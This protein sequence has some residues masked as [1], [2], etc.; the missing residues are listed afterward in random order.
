MAVHRL[1]NLLM[2]M[3]IIL[4][5]IPVNVMCFVH[6]SST[7]TDIKSVMPEEQFTSIMFSNDFCKFI[8]NVVDDDDENSVDINGGDDDNDDINDQIDQ[9]RSKR[10]IRSIFEMKEMPSTIVHS[11]RHHHHHNNLHYPHI[12]SISKEEESN[13]SSSSSII[14]SNLKN[15]TSHS[16]MESLPLPNSKETST[17][18][19]SIRTRRQDIGSVQIPVINAAQNQQ[20]PHYLD[21]SSHIQTQPILA[22]PTEPINTD[23]LIQDQTTTTTTTNSRE[24]RQKKQNKKSNNHI[25][26]KKNPYHYSY[27]PP[28]NSHPVYI[29]LE[30][31]DIDH[32]ND[33]ENYFSLQLYLFEMWEEPRL[34]TTALRYWS[35]KS[36]PI[37]VLEANMADCLWTP[38]LIF[39]DSTEKEHLLPPTNILLAHPEYNRSLVLLRK[40]RYSLKVRCHMNLQIYPMDKHS[41]NFKIR[42]FTDPIRKVTLKWLSNSASPKPDLLDVNQNEVIYSTEFA[43]SLFDIRVQRP[44]GYS[45][46]NWLNDYYSVLTVEFIFER[47]I[48]HSLLTV[49]IPSSLIVTLSWLQ[50]WFDVEAVPGRMSLG[51]MSTLTIMTQILTNYEKAGNH[52]TA[53]DIWLFVC[54]IMVFLALMEYA[55]AYTISHYYDNFDDDDDN[56][57]GNDDDGSHVDHNNNNPFGFDH[58][59]QSE[60]LMMANTGIDSMMSSKLDKLN[61]N[62]ITSAASNPMQHQTL[63]QAAISNNNNN[64]VSPLKTSSLPTD[65]FS[66]ESAKETD[67]KTNDENRPPSAISTNDRFVQAQQRIHSASKELEQLLCEKFAETLGMV[68]SAQR[69]MLDAQRL[70]QTLSLI[71]QQ[72]QLTGKQSTIIDSNNNRNNE[73]EN[74]KFLHQRK[75]MRQSSRPLTSTTTTATNKPHRLSK[76]RQSLRRQMSSRNLKAVSSAHRNRMGGYE[77]Q[78]S[79][80]SEVDY[81]S[82]YLFPFSFVLFAIGYWTALIYYKLMS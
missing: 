57:D 63:F 17:S 36:E 75:P 60:S 20:Q 6:Q 40:S 39:E 48:I 4:Y 26:Y 54:L 3:T 45:T 34:N 8:F 71:Q 73:N 32:I 37:P 33:A 67:A 61:N 65:L 62:P 50:F 14:K 15:L 82:R 77:T 12:H 58:L 59:G 41:C 69:S 25:S 35:R 51:I 56:N 81:C 27:S 78:R 70:Q 52:V 74:C 7:Q 76:F 19:S 42:T 16:L 80:L 24:R 30:I 13:T 66:N 55:L 38:S 72:Q 49:Y 43:P 79:K 31:L 18:S 22:D 23:S 29:G 21:Q 10:M 68:Q 53:V 47:R 64:Q 11:N 1:S 46:I 28:S 44:A 9:T 5:L 2:M